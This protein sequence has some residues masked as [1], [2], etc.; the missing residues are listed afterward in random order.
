MAPIRRRASRLV[1]LDPDD[2]VLLFRVRDPRDGGHFWITP[3]GGLNE[4][5]TPEEA[6]HR[7]LF[8]ETGLKGIALGPAVWRGRRLFL[9]EGREY[10]QDETYF[11]ARVAAFEV[12]VS[13]GE[14]YELDMEH[15][16]WSG[17][18]LVSTTE[19]VVPAGLA[20]LVGD[21]TA[22]GPPPEILTLP[23]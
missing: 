13:G 5:E 21:L 8:E 6:A 14:H 16:W 19:V 23:A 3:G 10:D 7:E 18:E 1:L 9:F 17:D 4:G 22:N 12:D 15:R 20:E 2:R 11:L